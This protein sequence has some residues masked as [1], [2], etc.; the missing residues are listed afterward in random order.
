MAR[1]GKGMACGP[2]IKWTYEWLHF[3]CHNEAL[4][5]QRKDM[6]DMLNFEWL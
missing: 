5:L 6:K 3:I 2:K 1:P 4:F